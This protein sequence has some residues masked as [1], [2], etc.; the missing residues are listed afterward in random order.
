[1]QREE[2][3]DED[4]LGEE[5]DP[6]CPAQVDAERSRRERAVFCVVSRSDEMLQRRSSGWWRVDRPVSDQAA[7]RLGETQSEKGEED[8]RVDG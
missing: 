7:E 8:T 3:E 5:E 2:Q 6:E 4:H 1:V